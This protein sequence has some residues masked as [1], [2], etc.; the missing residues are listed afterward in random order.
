MTDRRALT[1]LDKLKIMVKQALCPGCGERLGT[2]SDCEFDHEHQLALGG[3]DEIENIFAKHVDC[4]KAKTARDAGRRAKVKRVTGKKAG[5]F[6][7]PARG[8]EIGA[9]PS[10]QAHKPGKSI[11]GRG[12]D[13]TKT[14]TFSGEVV[15]RTPSD[16]KQQEKQP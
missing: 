14:R 13:K 10:R 16:L 2:L 6:S 3:A 12:F 4:H 8:A 1:T 9:E 15:N 11:Q 5:R 7:G